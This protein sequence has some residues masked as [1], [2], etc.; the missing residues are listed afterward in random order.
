LNIQ[1]LYSFP[2]LA[3]RSYCAFQY[4]RER[5]IPG[6]AFDRF[7]RKLGARLLIRGKKC[8]I[9]LLLNPVSCVRY[10]EFDFAAK[11][12]TDHHLDCLDISSPR[13]FSLWLASNRP[14]V[15][16]HMI[17]PDH[18]DLEA[19]QQIIGHM[20]I[21]RILIENVAIEGLPAQQSK[22]DLVYSISVVEHISGEYDDAYAV[23]RMW[24]VLKPGGSLILTFPVDRSFRN[25]YRNS[26]Y[27]GMQGETRKGG[28]YFFQRFYDMPA[29]RERLLAP[30]G[31]PRFVSRFFGEREPGLF[32]AYEKRWLRE[33][34]SATVDDPR[35]IADN[36]AEYPTWEDMPGMGVC[37]LKANK[38]L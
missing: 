20:G 12:V 33:G 30:I 10:F 14:S 38:P 34:L 29:I 26:K 2:G 37:G 11:A 35:E 21:P 3:Y 25:E 17:N 1:Y 9:L 13:L 4:A 32:A 16:I 18:A 7:G 8:G 15:R 31:H 5:R 6:I 23:Q 28:G 19:T 36:Y 24:N 22:F 27:Y